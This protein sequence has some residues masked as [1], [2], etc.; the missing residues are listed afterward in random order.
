MSETARKPDFSIENCGEIIYFPPSGYALHIV[1]GYND[2]NMNCI[3]IIDFRMYTL[4]V[5]L[6]SE[7]LVAYMWT[8]PLDVAVIIW[9]Q[10]YK[11]SVTTIEE[12][13]FCFYT[14]NIVF[15]KLKANSDIY[16][17]RPRI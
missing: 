13:I 8:R 11:N 16:W 3:I 12:I 10:L 4:Y 17:L 9:I 5:L 6:F 1:I 2:M 14:W 15:I 7:L